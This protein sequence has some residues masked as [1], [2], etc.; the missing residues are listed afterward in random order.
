MT[1]WICHPHDNRDTKLVP[2]FHRAFDVKS[3]LQ[4]AELLISSHGLYEALLNGSEIT[5]NK[6]T[7]G[8]TSYYHRIQYQKYNVTAFLKEGCNSL[9]ITVGDGWWRWNNNFGY[10]LALWCKL[11]LTYH[12][13]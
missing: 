9:R 4:H 6:F 13:S 2:V 11:K 12:S 1:K 3:K 5:E 10:T 7:P 8:F